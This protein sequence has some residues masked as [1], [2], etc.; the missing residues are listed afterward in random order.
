MAYTSEIEKL[1]RRV[2]EN[3]QGRF[4]ASL[5]DAYRKDGQ[6]ARALEVVRAGL[7]IHP[8]YVS[9]RVVLGR[10]L[11]D[12][13]DDPAAEEAF[14]RVAEL[15]GESVIALKALADIAERR[16]DPAAAAKWARQL[17]NVDPGNDEAREQ[18]TRVEALVGAAPPA[19]VE[20]ASAPLM[21]LNDVADPEPE[22]SAMAM[23]GPA[24]T[25]PPSE[26]PAPRRSEGIRFE[27]AVDTQARTLEIPTAPE[28]EPEPLPTLRLSG[29][30]ATSAEAEVPAVVTPALGLEP[31]FADKVEEA[32]APALDGLEATAFEA[33]SVS[34]H[35]VEREEEIALAPSGGHEYQQPDASSSL[36]AGGGSAEYQTASAAESLGAGHG[37]HQ[38]ADA[39]E[40]LSLEMMALASELAEPEPVVTEAMAV[41]YLNQGHDREALGVYRELLARNPG[42]GRLAG[43]VAELERSAGGGGMASWLAA[44]TGGD[45][46]GGWLQRV[47]AARLPDVLLPEGRE[48]A[49]AP[50]A[51]ADA[52][53][54]PI[55][56]A[57]GT[58]TR[59]A[60]DSLSLGAIFG[61]EPAAPP[62]EAPAGSFDDFFG[63]GASAA[64]DDASAPRTRSI[65]HTQADDDDLSQFQDWLKNLKK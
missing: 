29:M 15:D 58:P 32:P 19:P 52:A 3:P 54:V 53:S 60:Q 36:V 61:D 51:A 1:E 14:T 24:P 6:V 38:N 25:A 37:H 46:V 41:L 63:G 9:A 13:G 27:P 39:A 56:P 35:E 20:E 26:P 65:R 18:V 31:G 10:C 47:I 28:P 40:R 4:F 12:T 30:E 17:L 44:D 48:H 7:M 21:D 5:A 11:V 42:D 59:P 57:A 22:A 43:K 45:A 23:A 34:G 2:Q 49:V 8:D 55:E 50:P 16:G 33:P 64:R 62:A